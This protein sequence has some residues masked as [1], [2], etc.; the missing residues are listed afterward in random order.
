MGL[1]LRPDT[2]YTSSEGG[3]YLLTY[4]GPVIVGGESAH[5]LL[6][7]LAPY[8]DGRY[9][10][11]D[12]TANLT[13]QRRDMV[14]QLIGVLIAKGAITPDGEAPSGSPEQVDGYHNEI[15]FLSY[16][17]DSALQTFQD[18]RAETVAVVGQA[19]L[20]P[21]VA[22]AALRSGLAQ[23]RMVTRKE[24]GWD[25]MLTEAER[26]RR[27]PGQHI[28]R[29]PLDAE[30]DADAIAAALHGAGLV[31]HVRDRP[32]VDQVRLLEQVCAASHTD[33]LQALLL[34]DTV[35]FL[36]SGPRAGAG[37]R[38][39][40]V[41]RRRLA[42]HAAVDG[43]AWREQAGSAA[44]SVAAAQLVFRAFRTVTGA[45]RPE[46]AGI[47]RLDQTTLSSAVHAAVPHPFEAEAEA[48]TAASLL[49]RIEER[50][51]AAPLD[52]E[53]FSR[54][55]ARCMDDRL[56]VFGRPVE[57][58]LGQLPLHVCQ[59]EVS[60]P[61]GLSGQCPDPLRVFGTGLDFASARLAAGLNAFSAYGSLMLDPR[62]LVGIDHEP[63]FAPDVDPDLALLDDR[64][65]A[66]YLQGC[67]LTDGRIRLVPVSRA[68]PAL[69]PAHRARPVPPGIASAYS[70]Q[71]AVTAGTLAQVRRLTLG[72]MTAARRP[73]PRIDMDAVPLDPV[74]TRYRGILAAV[75]E[76]V[77]VQDIT[78]TL[79]VPTVFCRVG[80]E[81]RGC[82]SGL[83]MA[84]ALRDALAE[85]VVSYQSLL[86]GQP[87]YAPPSI[88]APS[89]PA[90]ASSHGEAR[91]K[92]GSDPLDLD[93]VVAILTAHG[94][95]PVVVPLDHDP[96]VSAVMP[97]TVHMVVA[98]G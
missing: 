4:E 74:G 87:A 50:R 96:E 27:D 41:A 56:G 14:R 36:S 78:G 54:R 49:G 69:R 89:I 10:L 72:E 58:D 40:S 93:A 11:T 65:R 51:A 80:R 1:L 29:T 34:E 63:V 44:R 77:V 35:W 83:S 22:A 26:G 8:L 47:V 82:A 84:E 66:G 31:L 95:E 71:E 92:S 81:A 7:R 76:E 33:L 21:A 2:Y 30:A 94:R 55:A 79:S 12:L 25:V 70:W 88:P 42:R 53:T 28:S 61:V 24:V 19:D 48:P 43:A 97:N 68:F 39:P 57:G 23:V 20:V 5:P 18:Y 32:T 37:A 13:G 62:R 38:W 67:T 15:S 91:R 16:L 98:R 45:A 73:F 64:L 86:H 85:A 90:P 59:I 3:L 52:Q 60:D 6:A 9:S 75:P 46:P 17:T